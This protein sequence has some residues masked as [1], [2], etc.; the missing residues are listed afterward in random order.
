MGGVRVSLPGICTV[1]LPI[2]P[3]TSSGLCPLA[4]PL[5]KLGRSCSKSPPPLRFH[6]TQHPRRL[7]TEKMHKNQGQIPTLLASP[8]RTEALGGVRLHA[9]PSPSPHTSHPPLSPRAEI[10]AKRK[11]WKAATAFSCGAKGDEVCRSQ[12]PRCRKGGTPRF[13]ERNRLFGSPVATPREK[14]LRG[15]GREEAKGV[16]SGRQKGHPGF[17]INARLA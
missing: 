17:R 4:H 9:L 8:R 3:L 7:T 12:A 15:R 6:V 1:C 13:E 16:R 2:H 10:Q 5:R 14:I 11:T